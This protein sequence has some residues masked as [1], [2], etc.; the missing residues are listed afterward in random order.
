MNYIGGVR[1]DDV[2]A[3]DSIGLSMGDYFH[4]PSSS[5]RHW[6]IPN[7]LK[8]KRAHLDG[9]FCCR[10]RLRHPYGGVLRQG[11]GAAG[12]NRIIHSAFQTQGVFRGAD[13]FGKGHVGQ[14]PA[15]DDIAPA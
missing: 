14:Q 13:A 4:Q 1:S 3:Q 15:A 12:H 7:D 8:G 5:P 2:G 10:L 11:E 9:M 6:P